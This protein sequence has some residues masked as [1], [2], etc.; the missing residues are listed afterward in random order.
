MLEK[1]QVDMGNLIDLRNKYK[2]DFEKTHGIKLGFMS[3]FVRASTVTLQVF[4]HSTF[5]TP[6]R[7]GATIP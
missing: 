6:K 4:L 2:D 7:L 5:W 1:Q 3:A